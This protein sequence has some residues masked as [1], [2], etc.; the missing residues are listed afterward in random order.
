MK[1]TNLSRKK[2]K[3][4][5]SNRKIFSE[6]IRKLCLLF[7]ISIH[8][9]VTSTHKCFSTLQVCAPIANFIFFL[10][11]NSSFKNYVCK[12]GR[13]LRIIKHLRWRTPLP[14]ISLLFVNIAL[15]RRAIV[16]DTSLQGT[17][18]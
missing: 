5:V 17:K 9:P 13:Y 4:V 2:I 11:R 15:L 18:K 7:A 3:V 16:L 8:V 6:K 10:S 12:V 1:P 14:R